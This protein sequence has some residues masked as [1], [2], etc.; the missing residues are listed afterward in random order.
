MGSKRERIRKVQECLRKATH[1]VLVAVILTG[2]GG[3]QQEEPA[4]EQE[5]T[6]AT[7]QYEK[8]TQL[9]EA[10]DLDPAI[11]CLTEAIR[12]NPD[13]AVA[14]HARGVACGKKQDF[15]K[16]IV[17]FS[18]AIRLKPDYSEAYVWASLAVE[19]GAKRTS[20]V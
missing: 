17:D 5:N 12:L 3:C 19:N 16:A 9:L 4:W 14:Y 2:L 20:P 15:D 6:E 8:G 13:L 1:M 10:G 11:A 7:R 18:E